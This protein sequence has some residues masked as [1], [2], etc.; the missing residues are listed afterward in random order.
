[1]N[2]IY[3]II[4]VA[5]V[6]IAAFSQILLKMGAMRPHISFIRDYL[7]APVICGYGLMFAS[8]LATMF[9]YRGLEYMTVSVV[10]ALGYI[11]VPVLSYLFFK[12][13]FTRNKLMGIAIILAGVLVYNL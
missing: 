2:N 12:E 9:A 6:T 3:L 7:N 1:M 8:V 10:E 5:S 4:A 13:G 11:L